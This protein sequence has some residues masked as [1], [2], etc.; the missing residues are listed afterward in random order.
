MRILVRAPMS[1]LDNYSSQELLEKD[2]FGVNVGNLVY[3]Y[4]IFRTLYNDDV[5][6]EADGLI[7]D[8]SR[9][10]W[11]NENF[12]MYV[13]PFA[14]AFRPDFTK[15]LRLYTALFKKLKIPICITGIGIRA[16]YEPNFNEPF[17]FD[18][19][20]KKFMDAALE[21]STIVGLRGNLTGEYLKKLGYKEDKHFMAIGCPSM[22][23]YGRHLKI[24]NLDLNLDSKLSLNG[25]Q[26]M[27][28]S[29]MSYIHDISNQYENANFVPQVWP[30][31][32][33]NYL[34]GPSVAHHSEKY[35]YSISSKFHREGKV[36][37]FL[38]AQSW[39]DYMKNID[40][41]FGS[42]LHGNIVATING[43]PSLTIASDARVRELV[44]YHNLPSYSLEK[45]NNELSKMKFSDIVSDIDFHS[46]EKNHYQNF[47]KY[48]SF[49]NRNSVISNFS[50]N[51]DRVECPL[52]SK[53]DDITFNGPINSF[54][55]ITDDEKIQR[56]KFGLD[57]YKNKKQTEINRVTGKSKQL[58]EKLKKIKAISNE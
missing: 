36:K 47:C 7:M 50:N 9:A 51:I 33:L 13:L 38:N 46:S 21:K 44:E 4:S 37:F 29:L 43:T 14:D 58:E 30:E 6:V 3:Q 19:D 5:S 16:P 10:D 23:T 1:P 41:S 28:D 52:D 40:L 55:S 25:T 57:W 31:M 26:G 56:L 15:Y 17:S 48:V 2:R 42:R 34:G 20:V 18:D 8:P 12:D 45:Y 32:V 53:L 22:Y 27:S 54:I 49:L 11:I 24:K 39:F 35:P